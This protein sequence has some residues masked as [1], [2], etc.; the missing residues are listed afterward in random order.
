MN[1]PSEVTHVT[2][3]ND[4]P[5]ELDRAPV[6]RLQYEEIAN[7]SGAVNVLA[8]QGAAQLRALE[9]IANAIEA[10]CRLHGAR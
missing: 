10:Y 5:S 9:R 1:E 6:D 2:N 4:A 3:Q 8:E 7:L